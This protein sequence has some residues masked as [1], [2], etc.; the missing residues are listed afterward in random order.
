MKFD[1]YNRREHCIL[2]LFLQKKK[3]K[4]IGMNLDELKY[5][6]QVKSSLDVFLNISIFVTQMKEKIRTTSE[7]QMIFT[8]YKTQYNYILAVVTV[9]KNI[10]FFK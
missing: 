6:A 4:I 9:Y 2:G 3:K 8:F 1:S 10:Y 5:S 7:W